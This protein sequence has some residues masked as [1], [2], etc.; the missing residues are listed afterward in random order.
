MRRTTRILLF[1]TVAAGL[2][3]QSMAVT[4]YWVNPGTGNWKEPT[5]WLSGTIPGNDD[6]RIG[7][8]GIALID[9]SQTVNTGFAVMGDT[10]GAVGTLR[11]TGGRLVSNFDIR[12][13]GVAATGGG[14]GLF[15]QSGGVVFMNGGN[16]NV[17][18]GTTA[19][20]NVFAPSLVTGTD[21]R[22]VLRLTVILGPPR[23]VTPVLLSDGSFQ[24]SFRSAP[25]Q[26]FVA[27]GTSGIALPRSGWTALG[28]VTEIAA[29]EYEFNDPQPATESQRLYSVVLQ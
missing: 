17:G 6:A 5:N 19:A 23:L 7:N 10:N 9:D 13:A 16:L 22:A 20:G 8:G 21:G 27:L 4:N 15:E 1:A 29:G 24:F 11:M 26:S 18:F 28:P 14:T 25:G 2:T 12:V 3:S